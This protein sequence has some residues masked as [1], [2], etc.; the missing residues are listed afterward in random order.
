MKNKL[1]RNFKLL[2]K[3]NQFNPW[4]IWFFINPFYFVRRSIYLN[5]RNYSKHFSWKILDIWC[6]AKPYE[7][8]FVNCSEYLWVDLEESWHDHSLEKDKIFYDWKHIPFDNEYFDWVVCFEVLEHVFD[9][10]DFL[11]EA[12]RVL[13]E[14]GRILLTVPF[15][16][17]E[18]EIPY[19][20]WRYSSFWL[21]HILEKNW[22]EVLESKKMLTDLSFF[23]QLF[24]SYIYNIFNKHFPRFFALPMI[25]IISIISNIFWL[26]SK[27]FPNSHNFYYGNIMVAKKR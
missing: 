6:W 1:L 17:D 26:I 22:F 15:V 24:N 9:P 18:H 2:I 8:L 25:M 27:I 20:Y 19:D 13:K 14:W 12:W 11:I 10:D 3:K 16:R 21:K 23:S 4:F 5:I 7:K